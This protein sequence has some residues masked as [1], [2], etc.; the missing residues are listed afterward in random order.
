VYATKEK[1][2]IAVL[3]ASG[4]TGA[5]VMRLLALHPGLQATVLT[6]EKQVRNE[7]RAEILPSFSFP[8]LC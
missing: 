3:G 5:E 6:G 7:N 1:A 4:Y 2:R 8:F